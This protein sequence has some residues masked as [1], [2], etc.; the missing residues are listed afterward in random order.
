M[1]IVSLMHGYVFINTHLLIPCDMDIHAILK[2]NTIKSTIFFSHLMIEPPL[3]CVFTS[4]LGNLLF[5]H[6]YPTASTV[7]LKLKSNKLY[8]SLL[9]AKTA[10]GPSHTLPSIL[11]VKWTPRNGRAGLGTYNETKGTTW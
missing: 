11:G 8:P 6:L 9:K 5:S 4:T 2:I 1:R 3:S 10:V 7:S